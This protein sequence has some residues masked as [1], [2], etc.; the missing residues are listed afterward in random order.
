VIYPRERLREELVFLAYHL[1]WSYRELLSLEHAERRG[2]C[3]E[4]S[5]I[6]RRLAEPQD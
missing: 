6:H 2:F 3:E 1:H 4:I 5:K